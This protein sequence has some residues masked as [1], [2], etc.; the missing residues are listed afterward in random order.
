MM[1]VIALMEAV[2]GTILLDRQYQRHKVSLKEEYENQ[3]WELPSKKAGVS[4]STAVVHI[5]VGLGLLGLGAAGLH[6][7]YLI[8]SAGEE[9]RG[10]YFAAIF[11]AGGILL[12]ISGVRGLRSI[13]R[14]VSS[15]GR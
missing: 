1:S 12:I 11:F 8:K 15:R 10:E 14:G 3:G 13:G 9:M 5:I 6:A 4:R 7:Y 2:V